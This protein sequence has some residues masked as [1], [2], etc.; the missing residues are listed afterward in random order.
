MSTVQPPNVGKLTPQNINE[1]N[2]L[3][4]SRATADSDNV[5]QTTAPE[6]IRQI[7]D[8]ALSE[9][10]AVAMKTAEFDESKVQQ[11]SEAISQGN[12]PLDARR[13]AE[14]FVPLEKLL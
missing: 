12:Y 11:I 8:L 13:I 10:I 1:N 9:S 5:G 7:P 4:N 2:R 3:Q 6:Q 14:S